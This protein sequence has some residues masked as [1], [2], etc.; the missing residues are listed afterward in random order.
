MVSATRYTQPGATQE[1]IERAAKEANADDFIRKFPDGKQ[2]WNSFTRACLFSLFIRLHYLSGYDTLVGE[3]GKQL[4]GGQK[5]RIAI[6]RAFLKDAKMLLLDEATSALDSES[7]RM[8]Q[9]ALDRLMKG[10]TTI[11]IAH[12]R[13]TVANAKRVAV[14]EGGRIVEQGSYES[15]M[16]IPDG[17]LAGLMQTN[18]LT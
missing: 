5:Q 9:G 4:S 6:A 3:R 16:A 10:R 7:E 13:S 8:V 18:S 2:G 17:V 11:I 1:D 15:L 14:V 12:R